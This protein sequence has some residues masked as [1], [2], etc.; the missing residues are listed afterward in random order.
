MSELQNSSI[1]PSSEDQ[2]P[3]ESSNHEPKPPFEQNDTALTRWLQ[4]ENALSPHEKAELA[5]EIVALRKNGQARQQRA[6]KVRE[7]ATNSTVKSR[8]GPGDEAEDIDEELGFINTIMNQLSV[9]ED[10]QGEA[11]S[12]EDLLRIYLGF[13]AERE[14]KLSVKIQGDL[15]LTL[16]L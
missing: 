10:G 11:P 16:L 4:S 3:P 2:R 13:Y 7:Y 5:Q 1:L 9:V 6:G 14:I 8:K 12:K 15:N